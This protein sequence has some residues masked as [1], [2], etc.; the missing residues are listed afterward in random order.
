MPKK[1][2]PKTQKLGSICT[3]QPID[4]NGLLAVACRKAAAHIC[5]PGSN[6]DSRIVLL[7]TIARAQGDHANSHQLAVEWQD[8]KSV[9]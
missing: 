6:V 9:V 1:K 4:A 5:W 8:R 3:Q 2:R 7:S